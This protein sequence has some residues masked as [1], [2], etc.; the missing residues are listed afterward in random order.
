MHLGCEK[1][2]KSGSKIR[3]DGQNFG[4]ICLLKKGSAKIVNQS[5]NG[6]ERVLLLMGSGS[7]M[8]ELSFFWMVPLSYP[9]RAVALVDCIAHEFKDGEIVKT[10]LNPCRCACLAVI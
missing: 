5:I 6:L 4:K 1:L 2:W 9:F 7:F 3:L 8:S 10:I